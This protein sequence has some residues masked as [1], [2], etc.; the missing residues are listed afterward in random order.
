M[1]A[2]ILEIVSSYFLNGQGVR[3]VA[4][5]EQDNS[6]V[7]VIEFSEGEQ[8]RHTLPGERSGVLREWEVLKSIQ[9]LAIA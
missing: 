2:E 8:E 9:N 1:S 3:R 6:N 5:E 7:L 4:L